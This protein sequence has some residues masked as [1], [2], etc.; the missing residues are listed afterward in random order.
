MSTVI[1][2]IKMKIDETAILKCIV[3][4]LFTGG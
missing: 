4:L 3:T 2:G 1:T